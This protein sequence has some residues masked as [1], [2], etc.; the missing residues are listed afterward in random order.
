MR[1]RYA[2]WLLL[3]SA[4][5]QVRAPSGGDVDTDPPVLIDALPAN[6]AT[7]VATDEIMLRFDE[8]IQVNSGRNKVLVSPP[9]AAPPT[10]K[11][12]GPYG[13]TI[14]LNAP[15]GP[16]S[17]YVFNLT[18]AVSDLTEGNKA[19]ELIYVISTG[20]HVDSLVLA[21]VVTDAFT[22]APVSKAVVLLYAENDTSSFRTGRPSYFTRSDE[23]GLFV[24]PF[25]PEGRYVVLG[26][27]DQNGNLRYDLPN[28]DIA[29][30]PEPVV[31]SAS[32]TAI[33]F[34]T[35]NLF[36]EASARQCVLSH[37]VTADRAWEMVFTRRAGQIAIESLPSNGTDPDWEVHWNKGRDTLLAWPADTTALAGMRFVIRES[38]GPVDTLTY[39]VREQFPYTLELQPFSVPG[40][41]GPQWRI[42]CARP[43]ASLNS[44][45]L[46]A[47]GGLG[48]GSFSF[49]QDTMDSRTVRLEFVGPVPDSASLLLLP[50]AIRDIYGS[51]SDSLLIEPGSGGSNA[52]GALELKLNPTQGREG[53]LIVQL[54]DASGRIAYQVESPSD[55]YAVKFPHVRPGAYSLKAIVDRNRNGVWDTGDLTGRRS[56][57]EVLL[58]QEKVTV[59]VDWVVKVDWDL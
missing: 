54:L 48:A 57:E 41:L 28:E 18:E 35:L 7:R 14:H 27:S 55:Q 39:R 24:V 50:R 9:L 12:F 20:D 33:D 45:R 40:P 17:T 13:M 22:G 6:G 11:R 44:N 23:Q 34:L 10:V 21:G 25:L 51:W 46:V 29:F 16:D 53:G 30:L 4:C 52:T 15:L 56:P 3:F 31:V 58:H 59:R 47:A 5:A 38:D 32:D 43:V 8:R 1:S 2:A 36:R 26:L 19:T 42:R 37:Q 49:V